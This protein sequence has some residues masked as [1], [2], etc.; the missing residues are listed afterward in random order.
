MTTFTV[1]ALAV[2]LTGIVLVLYSMLWLTRAGRR[3]QSQET[4][5]VVKSIRESVQEADQATEELHKT[6][7]AIFAEM[8]EKRQELLVLF[9]MIEDRKKGMQPDR[10]EAPLKERTFMDGGEESK[11]NLKAGKINALHEQGMSEAQ[12]AKS[13][14]IGQG[15]VKLILN[16]G[17]G[18]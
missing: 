15:E 12:I 1:V 11:A 4:E 3:Q 17:K 9:Y 10:A 13:L 8:E 16:L 2:M 5:S 18:K 6:A 14:G 7:K